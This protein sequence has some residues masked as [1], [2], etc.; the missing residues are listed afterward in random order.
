M[1]SFPSCLKEFVF[2]VRV[3]EDTGEEGKKKRMIDGE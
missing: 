3:L 1:H 2:I